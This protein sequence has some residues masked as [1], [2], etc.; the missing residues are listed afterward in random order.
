[1]F[2][3]IMPKFIFKVEKWK[4]NSEYRI[5]VSNMG[6]FMDEYK[7]PIP[8]KINENG[9]VMI[10][11]PY[12]LKLAHR[13]V[14]FTWCPTANMEALTVDHLDHNKRNNAID[15]LEW[16]TRAENN[17]RAAADFIDFRK[18]ENKILLKP[19]PAIPD[20]WNT[21]SKN[22][23]KKIRLAYPKRYKNPNLT[24]DNLLFYVNGIECPNIDAAIETAHKIFESSVAPGKEGP[25]PQHW[26]ENVIRQKYQ[27]LLN[28]CRA[29][30]NKIIDGKEGLPV[31]LYLNLSVK[32]KENI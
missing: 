6:H 19:K 8:V 21:I 32:V 7:K 1:M 26:N 22:E 13:L 23:R 24:F 12:G 27:A 11:T 18:K 14:M 28:M 25:Q 16:V 3:F 15:N 5:Y 2:K 29:F 10:K 20:D 4:W 31:Y 9:Y 17:R 30:N